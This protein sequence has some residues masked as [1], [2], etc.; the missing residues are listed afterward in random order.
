MKLVPLFGDGILAVQRRPAVAR[1][2]FLAC[3]HACACMHASARLP[4]PGNPK[5][6]LAPNTACSTPVVGM[7]AR[8]YAATHNENAYGS[9]CTYRLLLL[10][11]LLVPTSQAFSYTHG[12]SSRILVKLKTSR[13]TYQAP[14]FAVYIQ[15]VVHIHDP[16]PIV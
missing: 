6:P 9:V 12:A 1:A 2:R 4:G 8:V 15:V 14:D 11:L 13:Y 7:D 5:V 10:L 16:I 3:M